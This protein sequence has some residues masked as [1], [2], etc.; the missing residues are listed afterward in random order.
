MKTRIKQFF[1]NPYVL[2]NILYASVIFAYHPN[3]VISYPSAALQ[4]IILGFLWSEYF[5]A[6]KKR[7][8]I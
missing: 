2:L 1:L 6:H 7:N 5:Y 8:I 4:G 3:K